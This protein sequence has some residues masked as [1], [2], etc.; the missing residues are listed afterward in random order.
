MLTALKEQV[1]A[2]NQWLQSAGLVVLTWGNVS[3]IDRNKELVV[4][5]P[6]GIPYEQL[7]PEDM[8]VVD[9]DGRKIEG[10]WS[11]SSDTPTHIELYR[12]FPEIGGIT[13]THS[14]WATL[15]A[16]AQR[17]IPAL[18]TTHADT[19]Y[20]DIPCTRPLIPTE[21]AGSYE[22]ETGRVIAETCRM[23]YRDTP[24]VLV[25]SHGPFTWGADGQRS[26]EN[27]LVLEEVAMM[28]WYTLQMN[29]S[30]TLQPELSDRHYLRKHG[31]CAYYGQKGE[32]R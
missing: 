9:L 20:R 25:R 24:A 19:F 15:F 18:G 14:R 6:S 17:P 13:H 27:A 3:A 7:S 8:V 1:C 10:R 31:A 2:A 22:Q 30:A 11:P 16:Q 23:Q 26:A 5:K 4:I 21:I 29:P 12:A 32:I 28:A